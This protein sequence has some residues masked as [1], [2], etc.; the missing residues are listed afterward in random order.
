MPEG[1][2]AL[3]LAELR[4]ALEVGLA[5]ID[6][7]LALLVQRSDQTDKAIEDLEQRVTALEK[8][9]WP[10]PTIAVLASVTA[11]ALTLFGIARG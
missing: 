5:R 7:Q 6:G 11:V 10:L 1:E 4:S 8:G 3:A 9:R 2:V